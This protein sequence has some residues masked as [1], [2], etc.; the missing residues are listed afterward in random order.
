[1]RQRVVLVVTQL[2][3]RLPD[4]VRD[5]IETFC[6]PAFLIA[7]LFSGAILD[8]VQNAGAVGAVI[9]SYWPSLM[10]VSFSVVGT[11]E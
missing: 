9:G 11:M 7:L 4:G 10:Y 8:G 5:R 1:M 6:C 3:S 2:L